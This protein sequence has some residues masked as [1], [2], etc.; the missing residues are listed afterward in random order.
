MKTFEQ[1]RG[2]EAIKFI[3]AVLLLSIVMLVSWWA[4][5]YKNIFPVCTKYIDQ[6]DFWICSRNNRV[7]TCDITSAYQIKDACVYYNSK[8]MCGSFEINKAQGMHCETWDPWFNR[9]VL[10]EIDNE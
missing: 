3:L 1:D 6:G 4:A 10:K 7:R 9:K 8:T 5:Q 2:C